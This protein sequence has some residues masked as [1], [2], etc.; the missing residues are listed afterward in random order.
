MSFLSSSISSSS[1]S[2]SPST[3]PLR[4]RQVFPIYL[5]T[6][7]AH[8]LYTA[9]LTNPVVLHAVEDLPLFHEDLISQELV[10]LFHDVSSTQRYHALSAPWDLPEDFSVPLCMAIA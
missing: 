4:S 9:I 3:S 5:P 7:A 6:S 10:R 8:S 1:L 2:S